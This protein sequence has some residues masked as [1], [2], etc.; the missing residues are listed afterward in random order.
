MQRELAKAGV[1]VDREVNTNVYYDGIIL[2]RFRLDMIVG[3]AVVV[4]IKTVTI[5]CIPRITN[6][7]IPNSNVL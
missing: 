5:L 6:C 2:G 7:Q 4:E 1:R 3:R